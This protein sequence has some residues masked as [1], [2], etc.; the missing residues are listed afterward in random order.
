[1]TDDAALARELEAAGEATGERLWR[2][3][4]WAEYRDNLRSEWADMKNTGG[5]SA[6]HHQRRRLPQGVRPEGRRRGRTWTSPGVAHFEKDQSGW[7]PGASGFG[8]A[9]TMEFLKKRFGK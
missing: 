8:V 2:L 5:R 4:L 7:P 1:M 3:P 6:G 9:L